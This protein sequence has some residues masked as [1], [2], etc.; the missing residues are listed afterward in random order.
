MN[1]P[2][3]K[4]TLGC[5][6]LAAMSVASSIRGNEPTDVNTSE[7]RTGEIEIAEDSPLHGLPSNEGKH[8]KE[9]ESLDENAWID[10]G[11]PRP[12]PKHGVAR[13]RS[14]SPKMAFANGVLTP[15]NPA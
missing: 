15:K 1:C 2:T 14:Y 3:M 13:G 8:L 6:L 11:P 4:N 9:I 10:L 5:I 7:P 12:D